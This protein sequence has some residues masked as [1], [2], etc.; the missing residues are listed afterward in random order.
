MQKAGKRARNLRDPA[1]RFDQSETGGP[2]KSS[3]L[4][5]GSA[6]NVPCGSRATDFA[7]QPT[8]FFETASPRLR[9]ALR[10]P[11]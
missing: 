5:R 2:K 8:Y 3:R 7:G 11:A 6:P 9:P 10:R 1:L 4:I